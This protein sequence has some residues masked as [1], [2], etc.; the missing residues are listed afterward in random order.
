LRTWARGPLAAAARLQGVRPHRAGGQ[1]LCAAADQ[2]QAIWTP[3]SPS[4]KSAQRPVFPFDVRTDF[5]KVTDSTVLV[6]IT[7]QIKNRDITFVTKDGV[8]KGVVNILGKVTTLT[9]KTVQTLKT[10]S[11]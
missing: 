8:S 3:L 4:T 11:R 2:V 9:H 6:P 1:A 10:R 7:V 5:V